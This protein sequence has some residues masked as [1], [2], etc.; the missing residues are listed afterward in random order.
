MN[1]LGRYMC[2]NYS[3]FVMKRKGNTGG[4]ES[5]EPKK[6]CLSL[7]KGKDVQRFSNVTNDRL[8]EAETHSSR[9]TKFICNDHLLDYRSRLL[10]L[11]LL[12]L[13]MEFEIAD[14]MLLVKSIKFPSDHI[15]IC[16]FVVTQQE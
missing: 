10:H 1:T 3:R 7:R 9:A 11:N 4:K 8:A 6:H 16:N 2:P 14:I 13:M 5:A 12:P 15:P